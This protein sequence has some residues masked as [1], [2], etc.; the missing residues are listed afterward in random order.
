MEPVQTAQGDVCDDDLLLM[1]SAIFSIPT[2][3]FIDEKDQPHIFL[4]SHDVAFRHLFF[5]VFYCIYGHITIVE[6]AR[7]PA[8]AIN[9]GYITS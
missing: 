6:C 4:R 1:A 8:T 3:L 5:D 2:F 7:E 9:Y